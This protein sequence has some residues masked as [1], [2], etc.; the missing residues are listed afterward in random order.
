M[1]FDDAVEE[2][3]MELAGPSTTPEYVQSLAQGNVIAAT[4]GMRYFDD[5]DK[6]GTE[7]LTR[8]LGIDL[9]KC[10]RS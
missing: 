8:M 3:I 7:K 6:A 9:R 1:A 10:G 4:T 2:G 5:V